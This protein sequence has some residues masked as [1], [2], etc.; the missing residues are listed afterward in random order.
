MNIFRLITVMVASLNMGLAFSHLLQ[1]PAR[2][3]FDGSTW[4]TTQ[5]VFQ[6]YGSIGAII[7]VGAVLLL[8]ILTYAI[9]RT[10]MF[11]WTLAGS[12]C[13]TIALVVWIV[14]VSAANAQISLWTPASIPADWTR[15]RAQWEYAHAAR[16]ILMIVGFGCI[17]NSLQSN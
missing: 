9:R 10:P 14:L 16:A 5:R 12:L 15:W 13:F 6:L 4:I 2:M 11:K 17:V 7:E 3:K 8:G 1:L